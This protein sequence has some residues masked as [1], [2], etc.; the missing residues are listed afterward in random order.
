MAP[1]VV[2]NRRSS[3]ATDCVRLYQPGHGRQYLQG[4]Y[5]CLNGSIS[6]LEPDLV[7][8]DCAGEIAEALGEILQVRLKL[9]D[10]ERRARAGRGKPKTDIEANVVESVRVM[11]LPPDRGLL[12]MVRFR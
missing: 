1:L 10:L 4:A 8:V 6:R 3:P 9:V 2:R 11:G 12:V 7:E 5:I